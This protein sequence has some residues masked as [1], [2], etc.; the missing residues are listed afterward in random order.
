MS[1]GLTDT[2]FV[3]KRLTDIKNEIE[4]SL[5]ESLGTINT[6]PESVF[7]QI[8]GV[9]SK[10]SADFWEQL[11]NVYLSY[12]PATAG[13]Q[14]LDYAVQFTG[15]TR[16]P[17]T[18]SQV[19]AQLE[20]AEGTV[21]SAGQQLSLSV[22]GE[23][24][25]L[26]QN[27][28]ITSA[29]MQRF[30]VS[31][32]VDHDTDKAKDS[33]LFR[34]TINS[35]N[36]DYTTGIDETI[37]TVASSLASAIDSGE[38]DVSATVP[39]TAD[40]S[41]TCQQDPSAVDTPLGLNEIFSGSVNTEIDIEEIW[42]P[43]NYE[44][45][46]T[47]ATPV[48]SGSLNVIET[49]VSGLN[50]STNIS[51]GVTGRDIETDAELRQRRLN[52]L[53]IGSAGTID[54]IRSF[55]EQNVS[56]V[57]A[58]FVYE[59]R[60]DLTD[61]EGRPPHSI[62]VVVDG[63]DDNE[64]AQAIWDT[65]PG[66][67]QTYSDTGDSGDA[68]DANGDNQIMNFTRPSSLDMYVEVLYELYNEESFPTDGE[69]LIKEA[70]LDYGNTLDIGEDVIPQRFFGYIYEAVSGLSTL[71][72]R[73]KEGAPPSAADIVQIPISARNRAVFSDTPSNRLVI[74]FVP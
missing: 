60:T 38:S 2:G 44:A 43:G 12:F 72:V 31:I 32:P 28:T 48:P 49:P 73:V 18:E 51:D 14:S 9:F 10:Q 65:K 59:N 57:S 41:L 17:A 36:Y 50:Q 46:I 1:F 20:G 33:T 63:G 67:I 24:F 3:L 13:G 23:V 42:T 71:E 19:I 30:K 40:G 56:D 27:V 37:Y 26:L 21:I 53:Q 29:K 66:G 39:A 64:I 55:I 4:E 58:V 70:V 7:G 11:E 8:I 5:R 54:A 25:E 61:V 47:G 45:Q 15:I 52:S 74:T 68:T 35:N 22:T 6:S 16:L 62:E 69:D 34:V